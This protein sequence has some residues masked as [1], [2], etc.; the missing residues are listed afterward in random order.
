MKHTADAAVPEPETPSSSRST[1]PCVAAVRGWTLPTVVMRLGRSTVPNPYRG[2]STRA[3]PPE[4]RGTLPPHK[5]RTVPSRNESTAARMPGSVLDFYDGLAADYHLV[6]GDRWD[7]AVDSQGAALDRVIRSLRPQANDVLDC[8]CGIGTQAIGLARRG[9]R[10]RGTDISERSLE[11]ARVEATRL[12]VTAS[13]GVA[14]F[15]D[16][17]AV[18]GE[19]DVVLSCDN[20]IPHL[21][22]D[23]EVLQALRAMRSKL[24]PGGLLVISTPQLRQGAGRATRHCASAADRRTAAPRRRSTTRLGCT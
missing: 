23:E 20:A 16:L 13:F 22:A 21:L 12:G 2:T 14:D 4:L 19:F 9:Y 24:R 15:R 17:H 11:R 8:S 1:L 6:Y 18:A 5:T 10:V 7:D 3:A